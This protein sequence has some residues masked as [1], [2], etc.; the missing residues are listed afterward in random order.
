MYIGMTFNTYMSSQKT[1]NVVISD[2]V[3]CALTGANEQWEKEN[4]DTRGYPRLLVVK[5]DSEKKA[6]T[7]FFEFSSYNT[8]LAFI[9]SK[10][11]IVFSTEEDQIWNG[12]PKLMSR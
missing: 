11:E 2:D 12:E 7:A 5:E 1:E 10:K 3:Y 6:R 4:M 9:N 8:C